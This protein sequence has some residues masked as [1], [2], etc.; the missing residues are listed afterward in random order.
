MKNY[1][2]IALLPAMLMAGCSGKQT[3]QATVERVTNVRVTHPKTVRKP[4]MVSASGMLAT[5]QEMKLSFK[6]GGIVQSVPVREGQAVRKGTMLASLDLS[7]IKAQVNQAEVGFEKAQRDLER[8]QNLYRDSVVTL[9]TLQNAETAF[10][11]AKAQKHIAEFNL[12]YSF[13]KAPA[14]GK[15]QK[16]LVEKN[17]MIAPGYPAIMFASTGNNWVVRIAVTDKDIVKVDVGDSATISMDAFPGEIFSAMVT[18]TATV[19]DPVTGTYEV[20]LK[21]SVAKP[22]FRTGFIARVTVYPDSYLSGLWVPLESVVD[23][24][25]QTGYVFVADGTKA[26]KVQV[27]TAGLAGEGMLIQSGLSAGDIVITEGASYLED[28]AGIKIITT[29]N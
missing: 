16:V 13:I 26:K 25:D 20:E 22:E 8:A 6:T 18:E 9:E 28:G 12:K 27:T 15:V 7:E 1:F 3:G 29:I 21:L 5:R 17:E 24:T 10:E 4:V 2:V 11:L 19:A 14:N 23:V